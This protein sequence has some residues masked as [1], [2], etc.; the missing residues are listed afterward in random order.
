MFV[1]VVLL[2]IIVGCVMIDLIGC[3]IDIGFWERVFVVVLGV[4]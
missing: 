2:W 3:G 1:F 4:L